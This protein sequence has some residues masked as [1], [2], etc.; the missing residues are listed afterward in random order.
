MK[1]TAGHRVPRK[2]TICVSSV[3][4]CDLNTDET[5]PKRTGFGGGPV[6]PAPSSVEVTKV[7][8]CCYDNKRYLLADG[9]TS[10]P[11]GHYAAC[12]S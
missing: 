12:S 10:L 3:F 7:G 5:C 6:A 1:G 9:I 4:V 2:Q 11:Y 8:L